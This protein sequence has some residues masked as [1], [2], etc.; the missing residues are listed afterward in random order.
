MDLVGEMAMQ[1]GPAHIV[2]A[3][4]N[5]EAENI[6]WCIANADKYRGDLSAHEIEVVIR[7]LR[8]LLEIQESIRCCEPPDY[9]GAHP[10]DYSPPDGLTMEHI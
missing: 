10:G 9:D 8:E 6:A 7:S 4:H 1:F 5:F 3:D 2:W